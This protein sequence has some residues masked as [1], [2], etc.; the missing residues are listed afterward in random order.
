MRG[1]RSLLVLLVILAGLAGYIYFVESK[2]PETTGAG[3]PKTKVF[4]VASDKID[5]VRVKAASGDRTL[6][7]KTGGAWQVVEPSAM[8]ADEAEASA[9]ASALASLEIQRVV[10]EKPSDLAQ[11]GL[12]Q[13]R[14]EVGFRAGADTKT[15]QTIQFGDKTAT[16]GDLYAKYGGQSK[17]FLIS[18]YLDSTFNKTTFDLRDKAILS[19][20][21]N[22]ADSIEI[23][24]ADKT[25]RLAKAGEDWK[26]AMPVDA[27]ADYG[28]VE[29][30]VGRVQTAQM[31][32]IAAEAA[33]D[34]KQYGFDKPE[35]TVSI[36]AGSS[37]ATLIV[38]K[39]GEA[40]TF[41]ARDE[42]RP[43]VFTVE[44]SLVDELKKPADTYR[45]KD[46]FEFRSF[47]ATRIDVT[48]GKDT[49]AFEKTKGPEKDAQEK[50][51]QVLPAAKDVDATQVDTFLTRLSNLRAESF[52]APGDKTKT[53]L[54]APAAIVVV[55]FDEGKKQERVVFG[56]VDPDVF[57]SRAG[58]P[59]TAK[60]PSFDFD[61]AMRG[62]DEI[63]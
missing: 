22:K 24:A 26:L 25:I 28:T 4:E 15:E 13:P 56:K 61:E 23:I 20:E 52:L 18:A 47:T 57:A 12:A 54:D 21:R 27:K 10:E 7:R 16:G 11:Y 32:A 39:A 17:V 36:G 48:R 44:S 43:L 34:P 53:G 3:E 30:L 46:L 59:G 31:K 6:I 14:V 63:K 40:G 50:W 45:R 38:G 2:K 42:A 35:V 62:L 9:I 8:K 1:V 5:E 51:R 41:F 55:K 33:P 60:V 58:E 29:A 19:F 37:R 49:V